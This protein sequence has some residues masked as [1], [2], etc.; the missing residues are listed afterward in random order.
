M[1]VSTTKMT[2][3]QFSELGEDP[4]EVA[5]VGAEV[6]FVVEDHP[7][8][9]GVVDLVGPDRALGLDEAAG[10]GGELVGA[11]TSR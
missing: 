7:E 9:A 1:V 11:T 8:V 4:V 6:G 3:D 2:A 10:P 5:L